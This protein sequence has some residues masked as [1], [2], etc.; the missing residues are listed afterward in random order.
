MTNR[1]FNAIAYSHKLS[2]AGL[3]D[4]LDSRLKALE[5]ALTIKMG[6]MLVAAVSILFVLLKYHS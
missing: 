2:D 5:N 3:R 4:H 6:A 1:K